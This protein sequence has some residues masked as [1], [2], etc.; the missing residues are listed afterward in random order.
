MDG[1]M[2]DVQPCMG[3]RIS[4]I[5]AGTDQ[6]IAQRSRGA[7]HE[8]AMTMPQSAPDPARDREDADRRTAGLAAI[9]V[10]LLLLIGGLMLAKTL[11]RKSQL[12]DCLMAGRRDCDAMINGSH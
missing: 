5:K 8:R 1:V 12:E 3:D 4:T 2:G 11:H 9:V 6:A 7:E 10:V